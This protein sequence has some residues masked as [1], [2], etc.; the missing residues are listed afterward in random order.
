QAHPGAAQARTEASP[1]IMT[2]DIS[3]APELA[4]RTDYRFV[5]GPYHRNPQA[6]FDTIDAM[7]DASNGADQAK[8]ILTRRQVS[9]VV[10]CSDV[11]IPRL[12]E[13]SKFNFYARLG[14]RGTLPDWLAPLPLPPELAKHFSVYEV[15]GR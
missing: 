2:D 13:S 14:G 3:Y 12:F 7:T 9:L 10:R 11:I 5:A 6:I 8:A 1:I 4:F 15:T